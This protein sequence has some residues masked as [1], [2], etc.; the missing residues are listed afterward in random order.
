MAGPGPSIPPVSVQGSTLIERRASCVG[1]AKNLIVTEFGEFVMILMKR[2]GTFAAALG[3]SLGLG[4]SSADA[5]TFKYAFQGDLNALDPYTLNETFTLGALGNVMEGLTKRDKD[6]KIVPALAVKW[7]NPE[8]TRWRFY[9]RKGVKFHGGEDFTA[10]DVVASVERAKHADSQIRSRIQADTKIVKIDDYTVDF[11]TSAPNPFVYYEWD[12]WY[13]L[14]KKWMEANGALIPQSTKS[15]SL[16]PWALKVNGTGPFTIES[17]TPGVKTVFKPNPNWWDKPE[18]NLTEVI[19][20]TIKSDSTRVAALLSGEIDMMDPVPPQDIERINANPK[21]QVLIGPELRT[22]FFNM[23]SMRDEL[24]YS[25]VKGKNP[26]KDPRVR[27]AFYQAID[28]EAI[29]SKVMRNMSV[30]SALLISPLLYARASEFKR[31]PYDVEAAKKLMEEAGY[32][33]GFELRVDCPNDRYVND[34]AICQAAVAMLSRINVKATL[35][36]QPK[37]KYFDFA[38][39]TGKYD[40]SFGMLGWTPGS[41]DSYNVIDQI[42]GCRDADGKGGTF[43]YGGWCNPKVTDYAKQILSETDQT[44]RNEMI[45]QVYKIVHD[46]VGLIP[47]HQQGLAWGVSKSIKLTQ[48]ADNQILL[49]WVQKTD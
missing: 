14:S 48:R 22:I 32:K 37:A 17:H 4:L 34:E 33:D 28:I 36:A 20:Q 38:G 25:N 40:S 11:I 13:I 8:P 7:E 27:K 26:F 31:H 29:K 35:N 30:P 12:T 1:S 23:D 2:A 42:L 10:D 18:H 39:P 41:G 49:Y 24:K 15:T 16:N 6:L 46:E 44:K 5:K 47:L 9:L 45:Y 3:L 21:T 43:N 19:F